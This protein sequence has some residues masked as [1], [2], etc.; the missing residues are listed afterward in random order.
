MQK[1]NSRTPLSRWMLKHRVHLKEVS[2]VTGIRE[3]RLR[4]I[5]D[6][7]VVPSF[8]EAARLAW[9]TKGAVDLPAWLELE[10]VAEAL[11][12]LERYGA[13][14]PD[15]RPMYSDDWMRRLKHLDER[16]EVHQ[17]SA[18]TGE[19]TDAP[20][21][22]EAAATAGEESPGVPQGPPDRD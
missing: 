11:R 5:V 20:E 1:S 3:S 16:S 8:A 19:W 9:A 21:S 2:R 4:K 12:T 13:S 18:P 10:P 17:E 7:S 14:T 6:G 22:E 15:M